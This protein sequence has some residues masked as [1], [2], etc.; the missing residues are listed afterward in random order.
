MPMPGGASDAALGLEI[1]GFHVGLRI[2]EVRAG[3]CC[4][5][6]RFH[7]QHVAWFI[8]GQH[9]GTSDIEEID[10]L[11]DHI[12]AAIHADGADLRANAQADFDLHPFELAGLHHDCRCAHL[13]RGDANR[14]AGDALAGEIEFLADPEQFKLEFVNTVFEKDANA[15]GCADAFLSDEGDIDAD[16]LAEAFLPDD[17][18]R[19]CF[20]CGVDGLECGGHI[21]LLCG[22]AGLVCLKTPPFA[23]CGIVSGESEKVGI[24]ANALVSGPANRAHHHSLRGDSTIRR[25]S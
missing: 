20:G 18:L 19:R 5:V 13:Q 7:Q 23:G 1:L 2:D 8:G 25:S 22:F 3:K 6:H 11:R 24:A 15:A 17:A 14:E 4:G 12:P 21:R 10:L 9:A 16:F